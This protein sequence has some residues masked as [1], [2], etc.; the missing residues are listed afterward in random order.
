MSYGKKEK[1][2]IQSIAKRTIAK[3]KKTQN[4]WLTNETLLE[5]EKR[6]IIKARGLNTDEQRKMYKEYNS[7]IQKMIRQ[8]K[9]K[10]ISE[11]CEAI[12]QN[13]I[14]NT[15]RDLYRKVKI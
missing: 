4:Q 11:Q 14:T 6:R 10:Y 1:R 12:E 2:N 8:D 5:V 7:K 13:S 9:V 3:K 15:T